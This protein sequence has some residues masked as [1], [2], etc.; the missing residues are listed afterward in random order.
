MNC[1]KII[2]AIAAFLSLSSLAMGQEMEFRVPTP[3]VMEVPVIASL[4]DETMEQA[5]TATP[6]I[7][8]SGTKAT[9]TSEE[10]AT[11]EAQ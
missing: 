4:D 1:I 2:L 7:T 11:S 10:T 9:G 8:E 3:P 5:M 6:E